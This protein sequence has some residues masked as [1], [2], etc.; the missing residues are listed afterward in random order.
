[1]QRRMKE[2]S[3]TEQ[4]IQQLLQTAPVGRIST[5]GKDGYPYTVAVHFW[6]SGNAIY[7]H[8]LNQGEK[9]E[10]IQQ[11]AKV[12]FEVDRLDKILSE[13]IPNPCKADAAYESVVIR[14]D[15]VL[16]EDME[17]KQKALQQIIIKYVPEQAEGKLLP[18]MIQAVAVVKVCIH[19]ITG[20]YHK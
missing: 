17:E 14:G 3:M 8:G 9:L 11:C 4:Q 5:I 7:F 15:A 20:K 2:I 16:V 18:S 1:M 19:N 13:N 6:S 10:N 12:C